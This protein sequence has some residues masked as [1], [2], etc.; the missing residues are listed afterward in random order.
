MDSVHFEVDVFEHC[1]NGNAT[2]EEEGG[3]HQ[4]LVRTVPH[5]WRLNC[6]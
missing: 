2:T 6:A 1:V 3:L 4:L 5:G